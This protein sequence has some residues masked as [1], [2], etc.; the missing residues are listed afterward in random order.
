MCF[1]KKN[2]LNI[3]KY[4]TSK[5]QNLYFNKTFINTIKKYSQNMEKN[6]IMLYPEIEFQ[7]FIGFGG[8]ITESSAY[9]YSLLPSTKKETFINDYFKDI[10][11]SLC[12]LTIGSSDFSLSSYSYSNKKDLSDF[13]IKMDEKYIIPFIKDILKV[14]PD[15]KFLASPW[16]PPKFMKN[17]KLLNLGGKLLDKY[18]PLYAEYLAKYIL[19]YKNHG[20]NIDYMT[21]Q[22][23]STAIQLW[24]S[25]IYSPE[26][27]ADFFINYLCPIFKKN[28]INTKILIYDHNKEKLLTRAVAEF[29][30]KDA[31]NL[32]SRYCFSLVYRKPF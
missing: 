8:A 32:A 22:N 16:S 6:I 9:C 1:K 5:E 23:E 19:E 31:R 15:T 21:I 13:S 27:E 14:K 7:E 2:S 25:C 20:I 17:T 26:E 3:T 30:N 28:N 18:K 10:N 11:Y 29:S 24:E 12:R 4:E